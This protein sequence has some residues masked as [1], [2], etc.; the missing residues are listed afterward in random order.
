MPGDRARLCVWPLHHWRT[1]RFVRA[2]ARTQR[3]TRGHALHRRAID[4]RRVG[5]VQAAGPH[6]WQLAVI[7]SDEDELDVWTT[8]A[9]SPGP[10][11][12]ALDWVSA[13]HVLKLARSVECHAA[14]PY[15]SLYQAKDQKE[16]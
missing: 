12:P 13:A 4:S 5:S 1:R 11:F 16:S 9:A 7:G 6:V 2:R 15:F 3:N 8:P 14:N 10:F